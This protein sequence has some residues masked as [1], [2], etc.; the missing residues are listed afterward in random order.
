[1][2]ALLK[3]LKAWGSA[4]FKETLKK[5]IAQLNGEQLP[6]QQALRHS[7]YAVY[8]NPDVVILAITETDD[9]IR[10]KAGVF[11]SGIISGCN[12]ADDPTPADLIPEY[13]ELLFDINKSTADTSVSLLQS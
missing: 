12:C 13:C 11:Y 6:L 8:E 5:E 4:E 10:L 7:S 9:Y 3:T 1:M 2:I